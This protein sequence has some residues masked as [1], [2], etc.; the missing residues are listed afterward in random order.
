MKIE[1]KENFDEIRASEESKQKIIEK[2]IEYNNKITRI[3]TA[4]KKKFFSWRIG[5]IAIAVSTAAVFIFCAIFVPIMTAKNGNPNPGGGTISTP[6]DGNPNP[7]GETIIQKKQLTLR[8]ENAQFVPD[9]NILMPALKSNEVKASSVDSKKLDSI[10]KNLSYNTVGLIPYD[11]ADFVQNKSSDSGNNI[12][13][14]SESRIRYLKSISAE[15]QS[16]AMDFVEKYDQSDIWHILMKSEDYINYQEYIGFTIGAAY[17]KYYV[18]EANEINVLFY[19]IGTNPENILRK[20]ISISADGDIV[21]VFTEYDNADFWVAGEKPDDYSKYIP[22]MKNIRN[23]E[24]FI[25]EESMQISYY[26][27]SEALILK[28]INITSY[29]K[30]GDT[31]KGTELYYSFNNLHDKSN[32]VDLKLTQTHIS[33]I[34]GSPKK[35]T[36]IG[37]TAYSSVIYYNLGVY[38]GGDGKRFVASK[39]DYEHSKILSAQFSI[40]HFEGIKTYWC[41]SGGQVRAIELTDGE[42]FAWADNSLFSA[43]IGNEY[44]NLANYHHEFLTE[45]FISYESLSKAFIAAYPLPDGVAVNLPEDF[46]NLDR[47]EE[48]IAEKC[49]LGIDDLVHNYDLLLETIRQNFLYDKFTEFAV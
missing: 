24:L 36:T 28:G 37:A 8:I 40:N 2:L 1:Y 27:N 6:D 32:F 46:D 48:I 15:D 30:N 22:Y 25:V 31:F 33:F 49:L 16:L 23:T 34:D 21:E 20:H 19:I 41:D 4:K 11:A 39:A 43:F 47:T 35:Y 14:N 42:V 29:C 45:D 9:L 10:I 44:D 7:G 3:E 5:K 12:I 18:T 26:P 13:S 17:G 38:C